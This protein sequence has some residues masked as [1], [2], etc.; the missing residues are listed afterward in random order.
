MFLIRRNGRS[1]PKSC[2]SKC[3]KRRS[4]FQSVDGTLMA[5]KHLMHAV[6][7]PSWLKRT[8]LFLASIKREILLGQ[9]IL[10]GPKI[11]FLYWCIYV[12]HLPLESV[13]QFMH[14]ASHFFLS[15]F[16]YSMPSRQTIF[17]LQ[18]FSFFPHN[19]MYFYKGKYG[20]NLSS[21][22]SLPRLAF[23]NGWSWHSGC[24][25]APPAS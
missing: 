1:K 21:C 12:F 14:Y 16:G 18:Y 5:L 3:V 11:E 4:S 25:S 8:P 9:K 7:N 6:G 24:S 13:H 2:Q 20:C 17:A 19:L 22:Q 23:W 15:L 10:F